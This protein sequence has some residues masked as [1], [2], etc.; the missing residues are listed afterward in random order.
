ML[1]SLQCC[2]HN[3]IDLHNIDLPTSI[4]ES[5]KDYLDVNSICS[6]EDLGIEQHEQVG[7]TRFQSNTNWTKTKKVFPN[8]AL[9]FNW[10]NRNIF[11]PAFQDLTKAVMADMGSSREGKI[12]LTL[13][14]KPSGF[15]IGVFGK[16]RKLVIELTDQDIKILS[17][18]P[19]SGI[20]CNSR[21][22]TIV[23]E[24]LVEKKDIRTEIGILNTNLEY[25]QSQIQQAQFGFDC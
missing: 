24:N 19:G 21:N 1:M 11:K 15:G 13:T 10:G 7:Y 14:Q 20:F 12:K 5:P 8:T 17:R 4:T 9:T 25:L 22:I 23:R 18:E 6:F 16:P 3:N 2:R